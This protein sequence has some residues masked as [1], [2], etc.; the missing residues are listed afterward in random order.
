MKAKI[1]SVVYWLCCA[2]SVLL[3]GTSDTGGYPVDHLG[4]LTQIVAGGIIY[5]IGRD[6]RRVLYSD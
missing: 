6:I 1:G 4:S 5:F 3:I 2:L